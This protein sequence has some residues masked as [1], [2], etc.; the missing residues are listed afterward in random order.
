M[1]RGRTLLFVLF[2][3]ILLFLYGWAW[4]GLTDSDHYFKRGDK[5]ETD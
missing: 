3:L 4:S 2:Y 5:N 1:S